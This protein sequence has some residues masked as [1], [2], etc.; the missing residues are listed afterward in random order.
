MYKRRK[1]N[2]EPSGNE[3]S[4]ILSGN[5]S[6]ILSKV[7]MRSLFHFLAHIQANVC[8]SMER[9]IIMNLSIRHLSMPIHS[10]IMVIKQTL[11]KSMT[12][13]SLLLKQLIRLQMRSFNSSL[14]NWRKK[15]L[16]M[17]RYNF[18]SHQSFT[19]H[20]YLHYHTNL[21]REAKYYFCLYFFCQYCNNDYQVIKK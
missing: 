16:S 19:C 12:W 4:F 8:F 9:S 1:A 15:Y 10:R 20:Y 17:K 7:S 13:S 18:S 11:T 5:S 6:S 2:H 14:K 21:S 3:S